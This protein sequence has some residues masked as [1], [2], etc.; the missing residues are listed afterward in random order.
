MP[1]PAGTGHPEPVVV[2]VDIGTT[3]TK[4]VAFAVGGEQLAAA[5]AG[6]PLEEPHPGHAVQD[7]ELILQAVLDTGAARR[8]HPRTR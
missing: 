6:Y 7:P 5:S 2:G 4:A 8:E 1:G 3:S